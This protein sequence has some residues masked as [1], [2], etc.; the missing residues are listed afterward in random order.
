M[1][2]SKLNIIIAPLSVV[3][4]ILYNLLFLSIMFILIL[5]IT[6]H[7]YLYIFGMLF[8]SQL[9]FILVLELNII[10]YIGLYQLNN[11]LYGMG[12][13]LTLYWNVIANVLFSFHVLFVLYA[14]I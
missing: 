5:Y 4:K 2:I 11:M 1:S 14:Y 7:L 8:D 9:I 6:E 10:A 3:Y 13:Y 12:L